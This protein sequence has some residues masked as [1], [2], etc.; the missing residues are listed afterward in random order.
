MSI[1]FLNKSSACF[2]KIFSVDSKNSEKLSDFVKRIRREK[3]LSV[4]DVERISRQ[5]QSKGISNG[6]VSQIE[7]NY[8]SNVSPD[9]L[10]ALAKGLGEDEELVF[11]IARGQNLNSENDIE[12]IELEAMYRKRRNLSAAR[13]EAFKRILDMVDREL[14]R[15]Y[16]EELAEQEKITTND[17]NS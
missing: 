4:L 15:L 9:K 14:D 11:A 8:I 5:N 3:R 13:K 7:N 12:R 16:E 6:Y 10:Q 1:T 2:S 17:E